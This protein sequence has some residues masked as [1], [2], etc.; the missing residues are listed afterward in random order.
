LRN[1]GKRLGPDTS[2]VPACEEVAAQVAP[3]NQQVRVHL[4]EAEA[5]VYFDDIGALVAE[6]LFQLPTVFT[7]RPACAVHAKAL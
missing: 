1:Q 3:I 6:S 7:A 5:A 2:V 4:T